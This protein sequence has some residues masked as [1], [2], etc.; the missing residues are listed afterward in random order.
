[1][2]L[3]VEYVSSTFF[4]MKE[5]SKFLKI[6]NVNKAEYV[7]LTLDSWK[8]YLLHEYSIDTA[9]VCTNSKQ[10][11]ARELHERNNN[12]NDNQFNIAK[13]QRIGKSE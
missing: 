4:I 3:I 6:L 8:E 2:R 11:I 12:E 13:L 5:K 10:M 7:P 9:L 1:M